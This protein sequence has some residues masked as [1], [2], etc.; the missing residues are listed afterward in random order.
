MLPHNLAPSAKP[1]QS[2]KLMEHGICH[3]YHLGKTSLSLV[4]E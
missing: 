4:K 1:S 2:T 3:H